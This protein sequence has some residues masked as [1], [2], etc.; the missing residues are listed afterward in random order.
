M[1]VN[2]HHNTWDTFEINILGEHFME[3]V[4]TALGD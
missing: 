3:M 1:D 2:T 4:D